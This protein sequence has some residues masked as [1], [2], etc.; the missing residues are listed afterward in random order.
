MAKKKILFIGGSLNQ[1]TMTHEVAKHLEDEYDCY[2]TSCYCDG[3]YNLMAKA[4]W[5]DFTVVGGRFR[6]QTDAYLEEN[7]LQVDY[8]GKS[9]DYDLVVTTSDLLV[10]KNIREKNHLDPGRDDRS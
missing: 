8:A 2:F 9:H 3:I 7:N 4:G 1:T 6:E 10:Q 5:L